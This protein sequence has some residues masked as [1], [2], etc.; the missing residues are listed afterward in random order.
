MRRSV[1][2]IIG[3]PR[4]ALAFWLI[5]VFVT[6]ASV[7]SFLNVCMSRLPFEKSL[8]WPS[9]RCG[10][11]IQPIHWY[12]NLP[13]ISYLWLRGRCRTC[14]QSYSIVYCLVELGTALGFVGLFLLEVV[15]NVHNW[16]GHL[17]FG[18]A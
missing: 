5:L 9:S 2:L 1:R 6:G 12:D 18:V 4:M 16:P 10:N 8:L 14:G 15:M 3:P 11:C 17:P 7:G 13:I